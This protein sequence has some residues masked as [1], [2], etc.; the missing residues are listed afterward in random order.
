[1]AQ[2][3]YYTLNTNQKRTEDKKIIKHDIYGTA[4]KST[5]NIKK[6]K[7]NKV[8]TTFK[9]RYANFD[10]CKQNLKTN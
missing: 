7:Q 8:K 10:K 1:M 4:K 9:T 2:V 6:K 5:P 3:S